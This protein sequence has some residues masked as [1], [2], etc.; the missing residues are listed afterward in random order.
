MII[1]IVDWLGFVFI[2]IAAFTITS[3][4]VARPKVRIFAFSSYLLA[5]LFLGILGTLSGLP[6][7]VAQQIVL[8]GINIS[9]LYRAIKDMKAGITFE[10]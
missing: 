1:D 6:G 4:F 7:L 10:S 2:L 5:C 3:K 8:V 9:G